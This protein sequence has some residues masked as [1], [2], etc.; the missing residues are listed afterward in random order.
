MRN[1]TKA[2][3][4]VLSFSVFFIFISCRKQKAEWKGTIEEVDGVTIVKNPNK[5]NYGELNLDLEEDLVIGREDDENYQFYRAYDLA[6]DRGDNIYVAD[7]GNSRIQK[8]DKNGNYILTIGRKGQGPGEFTGIS[9]ILIDKQ[10]N[11]Y[12]L[13]GRRIQIFNSSGEYLNGFVLE[14]SISNFFLDSDRF[15]FAISSMREEEGRKRKVVKLNSE[16]KFMKTCAEFSDHKTVQKKSGEAIVTF[17]AN[18]AYTPKLLLTSLDRNTFSYAHT[19]GNEIFVIDKNGELISKIQ[20]DEKSHS[21]TQ[22]EKDHI[23]GQLEER[24]SNRGR[25]WP[26]G[27]LEEACDFPSSRPFFWGMTTDDLQRLYLWRV[28]S[29]LDESEEQIFDVYSK[30]GYFIHR[31]KIDLMPEL[32]KNGYLYDIEEDEDT[33]EVYVKRYKIK[34]WEQIKEGI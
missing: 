3:S 23:I 15:I 33:G 6:V 22:G 14:N 17:S 21:I 10:D 8:F 18:H 28:K 24:L 9:D 2:I 30:D 32:V 7:G 19:S 13:G 27:V 34:N 1:K 31:I 4:I 11:L 16:G 26:K 20:T 12:V 29:V 25:K 5:P